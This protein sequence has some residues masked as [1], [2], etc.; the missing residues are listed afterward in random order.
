MIPRRRECGAS[1]YPLSSHVLIDRKRKRFLAFARND[2]TGKAAFSYLPPSSGRR[3]PEGAGARS[4]YLLKKN[5][6]YAF[7]RFVIPSAAEGSFSFPVSLSLRKTVYMKHRDPTSQRVRC[8]P[9]SVIL[10][11]F[12][13]RKRKR[14]LASARNDNMGKAAFSYLPPSSG[15]R[16]PEGAGARSCYQLKKNVRYAFPRFVI[17]S[18]AEGSFSFPVS[19]FLRKAIC[20]KH[21]D[22]TSHGVRCFPLSAVLTFP[23]RSRTKKISRFRSK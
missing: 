10:A 17:P 21:R 20:M 23:D 18:A 9:L 8:F 3:C 22:P 11:S 16:C 1:R 4:C 12:P 6:R 13:D 19:L 15:R 5:V 14:F 2:D 7:P